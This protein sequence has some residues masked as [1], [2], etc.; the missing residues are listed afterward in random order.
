MQMLPFQF[1]IFQGSEFVSKAVG[2]Q[3]TINIKQYTLLANHSHDFQCNWDF[4]KLS[5]FPQRPLSKQQRTSRLVLA[6]APKTSSS[7]GR[8]LGLTRMA[9]SFKLGPGA[10][11]Q[12]EGSA[13]PE[14]TCQFSLGQETKVESDCTNLG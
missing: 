11:K 14:K 6:P 7:S 5:F 10:Y 8:H 3:T 4:S 2:K 12:V 9:S 13:Q 1:Y